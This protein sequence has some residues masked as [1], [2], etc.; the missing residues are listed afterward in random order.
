[1]NRSFEPRRGAIS[2]SEAKEM[3]TVPFRNLR[4]SIAQVAVFIG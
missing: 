4:L 3:D 1:M 2:I